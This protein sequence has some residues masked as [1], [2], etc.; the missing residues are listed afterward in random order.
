MFVS[1]FFIFV[2]SI[3]NVVNF[4]G[5]YA[6]LQAYFMCAGGLPLQLHNSGSLPKQ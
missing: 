1:S 4:T 2:T 6:D 3:L 5:K